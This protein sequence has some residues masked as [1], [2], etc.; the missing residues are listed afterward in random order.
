[1]RGLNTRSYVR[2]YIHTTTDLGYCW[3]REPIRN[4]LLLLERKA[5]VR[6]S[7]WNICGLSNN[8][9][10]GD[11]ISNNDFLDSVR[12]CDI[13]VLTETWQQASDFIIP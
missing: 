4:M 2:T 11:K 3:H 1:M 13:V 6:I 8:S 9:V 5:L 12:F 10:F 7:T